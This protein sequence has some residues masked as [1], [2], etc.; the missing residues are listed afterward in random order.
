MLATDK[1][2][3]TTPAVYAVGDVYH[4]M[5]PVNEPSLMWVRVGNN[6][7]YDDSNGILRSNV[8]I[9]RM[10]VPMNE[11]DSAKGYTIC[12]RKIIERKPYFSETEDAAEVSF[13]FRPVVGS[14]VNL[15]HIAD[16]HNMINE[17][18]AAAKTYTDKFGDIDLLV[19]NGDVPEDSGSV[20]NFDTIYKIVE[21]ITG[22]SIPVVFSRGNHDMR[23]I[24]A[25][26]TA[27][28][29]PNCN[30]LTYYTFRLGDLWGIVLDCGEDKDDESCEYGNTVCCHSFRLKETEFIKNVIRNAESEYMA[31]GVQH[32]IIIVHNPFTEQLNP[33][34][35][36]EED[37]YR[38]WAKLLAENIRPDLLLAGHVHR[39]GIYEVGCEKDYLGQPCE[40]VTGSMPKID[41]EAEK[42]YFAGC[43]INFSSSGREVV[44]T[45]S[46]GEALEAPMY[47]KL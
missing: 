16:S 46:N 47:K 14:S 20:G 39:L 19:L 45:D 12:Y 10:V 21:G 43:G 38:E 35:N 5:V 32:K 3:K 40:M 33:P 25:E 28:Y 11:L 27:E 17:P 23:G 42:Y 8:E 1:H 41:R 2:M 44:F 15:Y 26:K 9:H 30:G 24:C 37:I 31:D 4:I 29:T 13:E 22:G 36:I 7:Y 6:N 34:F 18:V